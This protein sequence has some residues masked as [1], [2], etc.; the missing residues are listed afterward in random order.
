[1]KEKDTDVFITNNRNPASD[2]TI[3]FANNEVSKH[4]A[5]IS[6]TIL[7]ELSTLPSLD[8]DIINMDRRL[9]N[10]LQLKVI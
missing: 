2:E 10:Y 8:D 6:S 5:L 4:R 9:A 1:L 7:E 3:K